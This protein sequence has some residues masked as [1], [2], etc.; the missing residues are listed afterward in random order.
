MAEGQAF[1]VRVARLRDARALNGYIRAIYKEPGG[2]MI[3]RG[4][5]FT[6]GWLG[7]RVRLARKLANAYETCLVAEDD[8][9]TL[10]GMID[11]WTDSRARVRHSTVFAMSVAADWRGCGV[12]RAL[13]EAFIAWVKAHKSLRRIELHVHDDNARAIALY[14]RFGF[15]LEGVRRRAVAYEDGRVVDDQI[16]ALWPPKG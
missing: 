9:G 12:G 6:L 8:T 7:Q 10:V 14:R 5:E 4:D 2:Y 3:T 16:M 15:A 11:C 1:T 13:L